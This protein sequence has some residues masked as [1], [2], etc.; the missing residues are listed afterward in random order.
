MRFSG[1]GGLQE[2]VRKSGWL[3]AKVQSK[4]DTN[5]KKSRSDEGEEQK[6][7]GGRVK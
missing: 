7:L 6:A 5:L 1:G 4:C 3:V 2:M